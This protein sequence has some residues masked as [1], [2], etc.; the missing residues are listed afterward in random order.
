MCS[1]GK[2]LMI[3]T[4]L[5]PVPHVTPPCP[6]P[7]RMVSRG[8][9]WISKGES[10]KS[11]VSR[12]SSSVRFLF[13]KIGKSCVPISPW[14]CNEWKSVLAVPWICSA[15][16]ASGL[17]RDWPRNRGINLH[18][19]SFSRLLSSKVALKVPIL[20]DS[21]VPI[22]CGSLGQVETSASVDFPIVYTANRTC[23]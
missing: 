22:D 15:N 1:H 11:L 9:I 16:I 23:N 13:S 14:W 2:Q 21:A 8:N 7:L 10:E 5:L 18:L 6:L 17:R 12:S 3:I 20:V 4:L 19:F